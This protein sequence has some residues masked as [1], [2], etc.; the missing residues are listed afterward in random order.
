[1]TKER[2]LKAFA[3]LVRAAYQALAALYEFVTGEDAPGLKETLGGGN[4]G[5]CV[6]LKTGV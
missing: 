1:M 6:Y 4:W 2:R 5:Y 3:K